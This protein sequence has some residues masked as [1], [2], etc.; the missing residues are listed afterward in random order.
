MNLPLEMKNALNDQLTM[1]RFARDS[2]LAMAG[3]L[4]ALD[5]PGMASWMRKAAADEQSHIEKFS[6][7]ISDHGAQPIFAPL[8]GSPVQAGWPA[9]NYFVQAL[10]L[11]QKV[12]ARIEELYQ[13]ACKIHVDTAVFLQWFKLEQVSSE[14]ELRQIVSDFGRAGPGLGYVI[15]DQKLGAK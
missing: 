11:E 4:E 5:L 15:M 12:S 1:E 10:Y 2:Y 8:D 14:R 6:T 9:D 7:W 13:L 3:S